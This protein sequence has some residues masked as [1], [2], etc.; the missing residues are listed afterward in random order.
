MYQSACSSACEWSPEDSMGMLASNTLCLS[1]W[2]KVSFWARGSHFLR[3]SRSQQDPEIFWF[4]CLFLPLLEPWLQPLLQTHGLVLGGCGLSSGLYNS[5]VFNFLWV[6]MF[7]WIYACAICICLVF[8]KGRR[9][10][11]ILF[12][13]CLLPFLLSFQNYTGLCHG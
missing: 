4:V 10:K 9:G 11:I 5:R 1:L 3:Y 13:W 7:W 2:S 8:T 12:L 6:W